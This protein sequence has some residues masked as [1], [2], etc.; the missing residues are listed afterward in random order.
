MAAQ[1]QTIN[2][3]QNQIELAR[4]EILNE[5]H[6]DPDT[7]DLHPFSR[8][9]EQRFEESIEDVLEDVQNDPEDVPIEEPKEQPKAKKNSKSAGY[10]I[11]CD[12]VALA[13]VENYPIVERWLSTGAKSATLAEIEEVTGHSHKM[14][15][16]RHADGTFIKTSRN[17]NR[18][19]MESIIKWLSKAPLPKSKNDS[20]KDLKEDVKP[21]IDVPETPAIE[22]IKNDN[23][24]TDTDEHESIS[25]VEIQEVKPRVTIPLSEEMLQDTPAEYALV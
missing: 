11:E 5:V 8:E 15:L 10:Q 6:S 1:T 20:S 13:L 18:M 19:T 7:G 3:L 21:V 4:M 23:G 22:S 17:V 24:L 9:D 25:D 14:I 12:P 2:G 16:N